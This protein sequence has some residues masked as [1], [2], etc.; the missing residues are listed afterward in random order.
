[1]TLLLFTITQKLV[2]F[3]SLFFQKVVAKLLLDD[4][5]CSLFWD[6]FN[7]AIHLQT[8]LLRWLQTF[9]LG[10]TSGIFLHFSP[11][12]W[13]KP[14]AFEHSL[15]LVCSY[16]KLLFWSPLFFHFFSFKFLPHFHFSWSTIFLIWKSTEVYLFSQ[17][18]YPITWQVSA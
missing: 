1:M 3:G 12:S 6:L 2:H 18:V 14:W 9:Q 4:F 11:I 16:D 8:R 7:R 5:V 13:P 17:P 15:E 10:F